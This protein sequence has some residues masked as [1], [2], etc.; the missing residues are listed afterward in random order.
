MRALIR[1][2]ANCLSPEGK[3]L[4]I[5]S[6]RPEGN[7]RNPDPGVLAGVDE[8]K[9][10]V[11]KCGQGSLLVLRVQPEGKKEMGAWPYLQGHSLKAGARFR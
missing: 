10:F 8:G 9:G 7:D 4:K 5:L 2:G 11:I 3:T 6:A 1:I